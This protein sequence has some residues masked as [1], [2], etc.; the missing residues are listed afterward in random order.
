[1]P[2][3]GQRVAPHRSS[4]QVPLRHCRSA[5]PTLRHV[6]ARSTMIDTSLFA[7][8]LFPSNKVLLPTA[9]GTLHV[10]EQH[11][12][13]MFDDLAA[14]AGGHDILSASGVR[15]GHILSPSV[16]PPALLE[17]S[18]G[19]VPRVGVL[20]SV[21]RVTRLEDG[22]LMMQYEGSRRIKL[23]SVWQTQPYMI[24]AAS[25]MTDS[26]SPSEE[27]LVDSLE[28][29]LYGYLQEVGRLSKQLRTSEDAPAGLPDSIPRYAPPPRSSRPRTIAD[30]L[31]EAGHPAGTSIS[32]WQRHG[33]VYGNVKQG[34]DATQDPYAV[35]S[36]RLGKDTRQELFSFA[37][38]SMLE[39]GPA[40]SLALL[41]STDRAARLQ[42]VAA[43]VE[44]FL[45]EQR[46]KA[47]LARVLGRGGGGGA[48]GGGGGTA[49]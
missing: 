21:K 30:Y 22:S 41:T 1:M 42:W 24:A 26:V 6:A 10:F 9:T 39:L 8:S 27:S 14:K 23:L 40:E 15:F 20:A 35:L 7:V 16:A 44:P 31:T 2:V 18:I 17:N 38:A 25:F 28:W 49:V 13:K 33:S 37:A 29:D 5:Q 4:A 48:G 46:A 3:A 43:A 32:M 11:F 45:E 19:G 12:L 36:E 34:K 47:S